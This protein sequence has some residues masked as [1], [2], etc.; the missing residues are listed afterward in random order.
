MAMLDVVVAVA[1]AIEVVVM[2]MMSTS[3]IVEISFTLKGEAAQEDMS[4]SRRKR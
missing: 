4:E 2:S 1:M 3:T